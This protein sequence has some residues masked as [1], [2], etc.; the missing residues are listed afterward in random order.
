MVTP[1]AAVTLTTSSLSPTNRPTSPV[2]VKVASGSVVSTFT[3]TSVVPL[4]NSIT[5]PSAT[6]LSLT[7]KVARVASSDAS[8]IRVTR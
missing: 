3:S 8:T 1:S 7:V 4:S 6:S 5:S 2:M